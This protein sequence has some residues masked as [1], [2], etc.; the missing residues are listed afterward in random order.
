MTAERCKTC[1]RKSRRS[2]PQNSLLWLI[3]H[4]MAEKQWNGVQYSA[5]TFHRYYASKFLGCDSVALPNGKTLT[6]PHSTASLDVA[7]FAEYFDKVQADAADRGVWL[8]E[9]A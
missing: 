7:E 5:E 3:Y 4:K 8:D 1:G 9:A 6:I 2:N